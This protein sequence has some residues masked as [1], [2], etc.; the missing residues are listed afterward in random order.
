MT[1]TKIKKKQRKKGG[2]GAGKVR[3]VVKTEKRDS[4]FNFFSPPVINEGEEVDDEI[5]HLLATDYEVCVCVCVCV[6]V[7]V[8]VC[9]CV[10]V[11]VCGKE[12]R[13]GER[14]GKKEKEKKNA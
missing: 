2:Q 6:Y 5:Q 7:C 8:C 4:F 1:V 12:W 3:T 9:M 13:G 11:C 10:C 14:R